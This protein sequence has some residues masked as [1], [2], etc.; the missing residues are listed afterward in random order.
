MWE[1]KIRVF[2]N[3]FL[4]F[5]LGRDQVE[6]GARA[7]PR[8]VFEEFASRPKPVIDASSPAP[9]KT[10]APARARVAATKS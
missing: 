1:R 6:L 10:K 3:W 8:A 9:A 5:I 2:G 4:G 7:T